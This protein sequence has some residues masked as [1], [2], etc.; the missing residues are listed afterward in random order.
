MQ[1]HCSRH[2][3]A[4]A[5]ALCLLTRSSGGKPLV[6]N[7]QVWAKPEDL[8]PK[9]APSDLTAEWP[10]ET[11][12]DNPALKEEKDSNGA[13]AE[14]IAAA[15]HIGDNWKAPPV[16]EPPFKVDFHFTNLEPTKDD[17]FNTTG[18]VRIQ[19]HPRWAWRGSHHFKELIDQG[20]LT[21]SYCYMVADGVIQFGMHPT[22]KLQEYWNDNPIGA[23]TMQPT[24]P[25][26]LAGTALTRGVLTFMEKNWE[27]K[28]RLALFYKDLMEAGETLLR[29]FGRVISGLE[30]LD[31]VHVTGNPPPE[32]EGV[33]MQKYEQQGDSFLRR[34]Y[35]EI[36]IISAVTIVGGSTTTTEDPMGSANMNKAIVECSTSKGRLTFETYPEFNQPAVDR[37]LELVRS[38][39]YDNSAFYHAV[40]DDHVE[41][42]IS[43]DPEMRSEWQGMSVPEVDPSHHQRCRAGF[44]AFH[45]GKGYKSTQIIIPRNEHGAGCN[46]E[47]YVHFAQLKG[48]ESFRTLA[49]INSDYGVVPDTKQIYQNGNRYLQEHFQRLDYILS[50]VWVNDPHANEPV[51]T[52][53]EE[54]DMSLGA[55]GVFIVVFSILAIL[56]G[57]LFCFIMVSGSKDINGDEE[58]Y[59]QV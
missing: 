38:K 16:H 48:A 36:S 54:W 12:E 24:N 49:N 25:D 42:G 22:T 34:N 21:N 35:P 9:T 7:E 15:K 28:T 23:D 5:T 51:T 29:P 2:N 13:T 59:K 30:I 14:Q 32:G 33:D 6:T 37:F 43:D 55:H 18:V 58:A 31:R 50:C 45:G 8:D 39:Y 19:I 53:P 4:L 11:E 44:A 47:K 52:T 41:F 27:R 40:R 20:F 46:E 26:D 10:P 57:M 56:T 3:F 1:R 17:P